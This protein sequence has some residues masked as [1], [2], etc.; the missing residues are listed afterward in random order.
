MNPSIE[1]SE[2]ETSLESDVPAKVRRARLY[3][4]VIMPALN[5]EATIADVIHRVPRQFPGVDAVDVVVIDD[6]STDQTAE[7]ARQ[8]GAHVVRHPHNLGVGAAFATGIDVALRL[9]ADLIVNMDSDGQFSPEDIPAL[10]RPIIDQGYGFVTCTRFGDPAHVPEMPRIK[11]WGNRL[12]CRL[13]NWI[14]W[15]ARF[16]DVSCGFRAYS[17]ETALRLNLFGN[18]TYTQET[19]VDL[20]SKGVRMTEVP[21]RV[22]GVRQ[23]GQ[24]RV[25]SNLWKYAFQTL[26][27][28]LRAMRDTRPLKFF[29]L[30][31]MVFLLVGVFLGGFVSVWWCLT[32]RTS[33]W[34]SLI[35]LATGS[36][37]VGI[38][39]GV[40][41]LIADQI[42]RLKKVQEELLRIARR[43]YY[44]TPAPFDAAEGLDP[45]SERGSAGHAS[46]RTVDSQVPRHA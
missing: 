34:T 33:P 24:S 45:A 19:F 28:I 37:I 36:I 9:G 31:A 10:V 42:G 22:R 13:V 11:R 8:A 21:L 46:L 14:I 3:L 15:R 1:L 26:P 20:A 30:F 25:A 38:L 44:A 41:A 35:S 43:D 5:E 27:I 2:T 12:M 16:T 7:L 40:M 4:V 32:A 18:F 6:G 23:H 17:R 39:I 29:G